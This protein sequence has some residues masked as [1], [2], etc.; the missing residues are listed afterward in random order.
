MIAAPNASVPHQLALVLPHRERRRR[1]DFFEGSSNRAGLAL[2]EHWPDWPASV[3]VLVGPEG[4]GKSHLAMIWAEASGARFLAGRAI[5]SVSPYTALATGALVVEDLRPGSIDETALFHLLNLGR[6]EG[7]FLLLTAHSAP[8]GW[9]IEIP[10]L[11]SRLRALPVVE[12]G[13]PDDELLRAILVKLFTDRQLSVDETVIDFLLTR[14]ERSFS[15]ARRIVEALDAEALR[16]RRPVTRALAA[17]LL[18]LDREP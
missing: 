10:D 7:A 3:V 9:Q 6:E 4:A 13:A 2:I 14:I 12:I 17:E 1:E 11:M 16:Q 5:A 15:S 8:A 18:R